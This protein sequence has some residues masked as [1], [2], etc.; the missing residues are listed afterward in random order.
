M[1]SIL[2]Q[3]R[4]GLCAV[5]NA[6]DLPIDVK[7]YIVK[8]VFNEMQNLYN[9]YLMTPSEEEQKKEEEKN[10]KSKIRTMEIEGEASGLEEIIDKEKVKE[11]FEKEGITSKTYTIESKE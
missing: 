7:Y 6:Y 11:L 8:D 3:L 4:E 2:D 1:V 9:N 5:I 10:E